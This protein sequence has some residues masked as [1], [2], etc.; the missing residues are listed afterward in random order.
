MDDDA[1][2]LF[3]MEVSGD[4]GEAAAP[5]GGA[6]TV[7]PDATQ[8]AILKYDR[9]GLEQHCQ[10]LQRRLEELTA[11]IDAASF[12]L[13][14]LRRQERLVTLSLHSA[15]THARAQIKEMDRGL[16]KHKTRLSLEVDLHRTQCSAHRREV[17]EECDAALD[18]CRRE[19]EAGLA[20]IRSLSSELM[21]AAL[22]HGA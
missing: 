13:H 6:P 12:R 2:T 11:H 9:V 17:Q 18:E 8:C 3:C 22:S 7:P 4:E 10:V 20:F 5:G 14:E 21:M 16:L 1:T 19:N 15:R